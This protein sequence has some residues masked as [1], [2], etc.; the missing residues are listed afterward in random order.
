MKHNDNIGCALSIAIYAALSVLFM[1]LADTAQGIVVGILAACA[2]IYFIDKAAEY[3]TQNK[4]NY[5]KELNKQHHQRMLQLDKEHKNRMQECDMIEREC[6][7]REEWAQYILKEEDSIIHLSAKMFADINEWI[8]I[9]AEN[10]LRYKPH[11]STKGAD[12]I[13]EMRE[14]ARYHMTEYRKMQYKKGILCKTFPELEQYFEDDHNESIEAIGIYSN[15][16]DLKE[17]YDRR[18]NYLSKDE[19]QD[20][21]ETDKS[22]LALD[23]YNQRPKGNW[24]I[25]IEYEMYIEYYFREKKKCKTIPHGSLNGL[26]DLGRDIIAEEEKNGI[27]ITYIIQCKRYSAT[28]QIHENTICQLYGTAIEYELSHKESHGVIVPI[29]YTTTD[30]SPMAAKFAER[31]GIKT[32]KTPMSEYPQIKC[33]VGKDGEKIYHLPFD[34]QYYNVKIDKPEEFYAWTVKEA[35]EAGFRRAKKHVF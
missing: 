9:D 20:L 10:Y 21:S 4:K 29:L 8:F 7:R 28:K 11:P 15:T 34:Q 22:Q 32:C 33:N 26:E 30:L 1:I 17:S 14:K 27:H 5:E 2:L 19:L 13:K 31:L 35:E 24:T 25:G 12:V 18:A 23:R 16:E 6:K 3:Y